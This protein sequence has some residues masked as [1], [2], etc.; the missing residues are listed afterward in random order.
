MYRSNPLIVRMVAL[1]MLPAL[2]MVESAAAAAA[3]VPPAVTVRYNDL[4][5]DSSADIASLYRRIESAAT[6]VCEPAEGPQSVSRMQWTA[7]NECF[8]HAIAKA[9]RAVHNDKLR[10]YHWQRV[11]GWD[12][13][14]AQ[15]PT[16]VARR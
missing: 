1:L 4:N 10:A 11:R 12:A 13:E 8:Y 7:W 9:V 2:F 14:E 5:L 3:E 6:V 16:S 15:A